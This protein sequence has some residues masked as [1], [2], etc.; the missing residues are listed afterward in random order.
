[1][2]DN[3]TKILDNIL[4]VI[5]K[6][7]I[8]SATLRKEMNQDFENN[9]IVMEIFTKN[10]PYDI[11]Y[12]KYKD[13]EDLINGK[14]YDIDI[15]LTEE[16]YAEHNMDIDYIMSDYYEGVSPNHCYSIYND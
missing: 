2:V 16:E 13:I 7:E 5:D 10:N 9:Y 3:H 15:I 4:N 8:V 11:S 6:E 1:M 14:K 12:R